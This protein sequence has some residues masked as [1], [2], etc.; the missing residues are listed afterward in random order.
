MDFVN[1]KKH[2]ERVMWKNS[3]NWFLVMGKPACK[4]IQKSAV[5]LQKGDILNLVNGAISCILWK[6]SWRGENQIWKQW[7]SKEAWCSLETYFWKW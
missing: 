5:S 4:D 6:S 1:S 3:A 2:V 7:N